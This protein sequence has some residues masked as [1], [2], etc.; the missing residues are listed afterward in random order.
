MISQGVL[1]AST[2]REGFAISSTLYLLLSTPLNKCKSVFIV[3]MYTLN[4]PLFLAYMDSFKNK[5]SFGNIFV[6]PKN[7]LFLKMIFS[8]A[9]VVAKFL[10][11]QTCG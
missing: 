2:T 11:H 4:V 10:C 9:K 7:L 8:A 6:Y 3:L 5:M 1:H